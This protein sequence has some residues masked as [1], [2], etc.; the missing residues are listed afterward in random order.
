M[1][2]Y[3]TS[4]GKPSEFSVSDKPKFCSG[5]GTGFSLG[6]SPPKEE[7]EETTPAR[8][9]EENVSYS[10]N[11][12]KLDVDVTPSRPP[13]ET[14]GYLIDNP[15]PNT[16]AD[17]PIPNAPERSREQFLESFKREAGSLRNK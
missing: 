6:E 11:L 15:A 5:C 13:S 17:E 2:K 1:K 4:C 14:L 10:G 9:K 8:E 7:K 12:S 3:C 16:L